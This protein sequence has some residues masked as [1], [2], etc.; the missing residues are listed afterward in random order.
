MK[1]E[2][3]GKNLTVT[4]A[5]KNQAEKKFAKLEKYFSDD[6]NVRA[7]FSHIK[8]NQKVEAT[9]FLKGS[10]LRAEEATDDMYASIDKVI[11]VLERQIR[12]YKTKI[13]KRNQ[14]N[15]TIRFENFEEPKEE[16]KEKIV[17]RKSFD[18]RPMHEEEAILQMEL[19]NHNFFVFL[20]EETS[21]VEVLYKRKDGDYGLIETNLA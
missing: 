2:L 9:V 7:V 18:L 20:N 1:L 21:N 8:T 6:V 17:R 12:K 19:L 10:T 15:K 14:D 4:D 16:P 13:K 11:D 5:L 3:I